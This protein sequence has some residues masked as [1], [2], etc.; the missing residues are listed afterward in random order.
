ME[1]DYAGI[2]EE[3]DAEASELRLSVIEH[4]DRQHADE[5]ADLESLNTGDVYLCGHKRQIAEC[6]ARE[7]ALWSALEIIR[8]IEARA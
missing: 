7:A 4:L 8:N 3:L 5:C 6:E 2:Q 1:T